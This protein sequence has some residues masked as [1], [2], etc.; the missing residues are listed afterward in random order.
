MNRII[1]FNNRRQ[2]ERMSHIYKNDSITN[3]NIHNTISN[4][5]VKK[6]I[7]VYQIGYKNGRQ[8][9]GLGDFLRGCITLS[10][11]CN[12]YNLEFGIDF[13]NHIM[14][15]YIC[16]TNNSENVLYN[17]IKLVGINNIFEQDLS[18]IIQCINETKGEVCYL[19]TT[20]N[21]EQNVSLLSI[22]KQSII[23]KNLL[24]SIEI[25]ENINKIY[26]KCG[27]K[28][29]EYGIIQIRGGD[30]F[31]VHK[32]FEQYYM[33]TFV[34]FILKKL[35]NHKINSKKYIIISDNDYLKKY[36][37]ISNPNFIV[38]NNG[39]L[40]VHLAFGSMDDS[41]VM[42]TI[43]DFFLLA[44]SSEVISFSRY[45]HG[46]GFSKWGSFIFSRPFT[47]YVHTEIDSNFNNFLSRLVTIQPL[48]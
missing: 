15:K 11:L 42:W 1:G 16:S 39:I 27:I 14:G 33:T 6:I 41:N 9:G 26:S 10:M 4:N 40:P 44:C 20:I 30:N 12:K 29:N 46:S 28:S 13:N 5:N 45:M 21:F 3:V 25:T 38:I 23:V 24:P 31:L 7:N 37:K 22:Y 47:Q 8:P 36:I 18:E 43:I 19:C 48:A 34:Q 17:D 32:Q 35:R 2:N